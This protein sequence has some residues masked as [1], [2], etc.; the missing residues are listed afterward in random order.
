[1]DPI[2]PIL[3]TEAVSA[4][5]MTGIRMYLDSRESSRASSRERG[6]QRVE[7]PE[8]NIGDI[9]GETREADL[10]DLAYGIEVKKGGLIEG[11]NKMKK[12]AID[13]VRKV[14]SRGNTP[15]RE[16][17]AESDIIPEPTATP[18]MSREMCRYYW[19]KYREE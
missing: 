11:V 7:S 16:R 19:I 8:I 17:P 15:L 6:S 2:L 10:E 1:M 9:H 3:L 12:R 18:K 13:F 5:T 4:A 14:A